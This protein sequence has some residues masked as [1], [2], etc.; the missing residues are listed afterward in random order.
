MPTQVHDYGTWTKRD[1]KVH[2]RV[3]KYNA[4]HVE[5]EAHK[6][7]KGTITK[8]ATG[9]EEGNKIYRCTVCDATKEEIIPVLTHTHQLIKTSQKKASCTEDGTIEYWQCVSCKK[10]YI[11][12]NATTELKEDELRI[13]AFGHK[14]VIDPAIAPTTSTT[15]LTEGSHCSVC[16]IV[17][18]KQEIIPKLSSEISETEEPTPT[19]STDPDHPS[20]EEKEKQ[21]TEQKGDGDP[22]GSSYGRLCAHV[23]KSSKTSNTLGWNKVSG[24]SG[25][26]VYGNR[27][28]TAFRFVK[29]AEVKGTSYVLNR[30]QKGTYYKYLVVAYKNVSTA[31]TV[32]TTS[33]TMHAA[34]T[35]GKVGNCKNLKLNKA[36]VTLKRKKTFKFTRPDDDPYEYM[37][38]NDI[39]ITGNSN[40]AEGA[41]EYYSPYYFGY[42]CE[43]EGD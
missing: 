9:T 12:S 8:P 20:V 31:R 24:A 18:K 33:K 39:C 27:C 25:Y 14:P 41:P 23:K 40:G 26:I 19:I 37:T 4:D 7:D 6:W 17:I 21:I 11:D 30:L 34:T 10:F 38:W 13:S 1:D 29:I 36:K 42:I 3:C 15:G 22:K 16:N 35:G 32:I 5:E 43:W 28:G 2:Q